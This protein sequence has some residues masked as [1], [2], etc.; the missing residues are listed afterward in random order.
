M[1]QDINR[2]PKTGERYTL[3]FRVRATP[4]QP[5]GRGLAEFWELGTAPINGFAPTSVS[6]SVP[7]ASS[8]TWTE[9][10]VSMC[11][12]N[13]DNFTL[14]TK[15]FT[16]GTTSLDFDNVR[17]T[18]LPDPTCVINP[19]VLNSPDLT[20]FPAGSS[21]LIDGAFESGLA[22][23]GACPNP[24]YKY[25]TQNSSG[26]GNVT[27]T[28]PSAAFGSRGKHMSV[29]VDRVGWDANQACYR[30]GSVPQTNGDVHYFKAWVR[31]G[32]GTNFKATL[33]MSGLTHRYDFTCGPT[34]DYDC[35]RNEPVV[36]GVSFT[37][38]ST[39][40]QIVVAW[41][42]PK[43]YPNT[44]TYN[45]TFEMHV[46]PGQAGKALL[47]DEATETG[48]LV[49]SPCPTTVLKE[50]AGVTTGNPPPPPPPPPPGVHF[51]QDGVP[52]ILELADTAN[53]D[54]I[55]LNGLGRAV[56]TT[57]KTRCLVVTP[58]LAASGFL[59]VIGD[60]ENRADST[61][62]LIRDGNIGLIQGPCDARTDFLVSDSPG[63]I[64]TSLQ[65]PIRGLEQNSPCLSRSGTNLTFA[66]C[67]ATPAITQMWYD[68]KSAP[69]TDPCVSLPAVSPPVPPYRVDLPGF[70]YNVATSGFRDGL[71]EDDLRVVAGVAS[72][73]P[74]KTKL[75]SKLL[76][77]YV[78][79]TGNY[80]LTQQEMNRV[81]KA[82]FGS[83]R[84]IPEWLFRDVVQSSTGLAN[85]QSFTTSVTLGS[86]TA[87]PA[88]SRD[89]KSRNGQPTDAGLETNMTVFPGWL[90]ISSPDN[91]NPDYPQSE[92]EVANGL[93]SFDLKTVGQV[94]SGYKCFRVHLYD[95]YMFA[96]TNLAIPG[97][98]WWL[99]N[100]AANLHR[101]GRARNFDILGVTQATCFLSPGA[102][103]RIVCPEIAG[104]N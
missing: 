98:P 37:A 57:D 45:G 55:M 42:P 11:A 79:K 5:N 91:L 28:N 25:G 65:F 16:Y 14:R 77:R 101:V 93:G 83:S 85:S 78:N 96:K 32:D 102:L 23:W 51:F 10:S 7:F 74:L 35:G 70:Q 97:A 18:I 44:I 84:S 47:V 59:L 41:Q 89:G 48:T 58:F 66:L 69:R 1:C 86:V 34:Y 53:Y 24:Y 27:L 36:T 99:D 2:V 43:T 87:F 4:G 104:L 73:G 12:R 81:V 100:D 75:A 60:V 64:Q 31:S 13:P 82:G 90:R 92:S 68:K 19:G 46:V 39:W 103:A 76:Y 6:V 94:I 63:L 8:P 52:T 22:G 40:Q 50:C 72:F 71:V 9:E 26:L 67:G 20:N 95:R 49:A 61:D 17:L 29:T 88:Q 56:L 54:C 62:C 15:L 21:N 30:F 80:T 38:T 3:N 33:Y